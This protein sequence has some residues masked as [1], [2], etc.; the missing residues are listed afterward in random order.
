MANSIYGLC[1]CEN[2]YTALLQHVSHYLTCFHLVLEGYAAV[3]YQL[4][5]GHRS[6][7]DVQIEHS[8]HVVRMV[9]I[10]YFAVTVISLAHELQ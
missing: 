8:P 3:V 4:L 1:S 10:Q 7:R 6:V 9:E 2:Q 5:Q